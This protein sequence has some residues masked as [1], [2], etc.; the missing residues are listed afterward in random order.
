VRTILTRVE[1]RGEKRSS[2]VTKEVVFG[3]RDALGEL[4][5]QKTEAFSLGPNTRPAFFPR[6]G[7]SVILK[8]NCFD[9][10]TLSSLKGS[11]VHLCADFRSLWRTFITPY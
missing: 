2:S 8:V 9:G 7:I 10:E 4:A 11:L 1:Y 6:L 5:L 3:A